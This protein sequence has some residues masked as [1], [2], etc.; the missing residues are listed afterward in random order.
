MKKNYI[1][2]VT[3]ALLAVSCAKGIDNDVSCENNVTIT[4][5]SAETKDTKSTLIDGGTNVYWEPEDEIKLFTM[6]SSIR[7]QTAI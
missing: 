2:F 3:A 6:G 7:L 1:L 5:Y 4:A